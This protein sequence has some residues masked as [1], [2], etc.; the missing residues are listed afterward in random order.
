VK[1]FHQRLGVLV[2]EVPLNRLK[3][4]EAS[5]I[6]SYI[7]PDRKIVST[8]HVETVTAANQV[9]N[10]ITNTT[11]DGSGIGIAILDSGLDTAHKLLKKGTASRVVYSQ[12]FTGDNIVGDTNGHGSHVASLA[13]GANGFAG[14]AYAGI[15]PSANL[16]N[17][18]VLDDYGAGSASSIIAALDWCIANKATYNIRVINMSLGTTAVE[19]YQ[20]DPLCLAARR[21]HDAGIVVV[22]AAGNEGKNAAGQKVFGAIHSPGTDPSVIT[23]G[24]TNTFGTESRSDDRIASFS[25]RG[26]T[27]GHFTDENGVR[28]FDNLIKPDLVAPGNKLI[29]AQSANPRSTLLPN[30]RVQQSPSLDTSST[31][32]KTSKVMFMSGTSMAAPVVAGAAALMLQANPNLTPNLVKAILMYTAQPIQGANSFEQGAG[33]LNLEGAIRIARLVMPNPQTLAN[34]AAMLTGALPS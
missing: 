31:T 14:G 2:A 32:D 28:H 24:A 23:V 19:S 29:G 33:Q 25:S 11:L 6:L 3:E 1:K 7:S 16:L 8:G 5:E 26:P 17:L 34:G 4:L 15:A 27:R 9:R 20:F 22:C 13:A 12:D 30:K 10:V 21:A 18:R